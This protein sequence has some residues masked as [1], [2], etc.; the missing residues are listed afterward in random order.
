MRIH[1]LLFRCF[2]PALAAALLFLPRIERAQGAHG[3]LKSDMDP[4]ADACRDFP[5]YADGG[6]L[7]RNPVPAAYSRWGTF[8]ILANHNREI[9]RS[10]LDEAAADRKAA[11]GSERQKLG[12]FY[13]ACMD[14]SKAEADGAKPLEPELER[15]AKVH[16]RGSLDSEIARLQTEGADVLF[17]FGSQQDKKN[18]NEVIAAASQGG[19]GLPDRDYYLKTDEKSKTLRE[20]Y[21]AHVAR[22]LELLGDSPEAARSGAAAVMAIETRLAEA[23]M[24]R[25]ERRDADATYHPMAVAGLETLAP[26]FGWKSF[27]EAVDSPPVKT[28]NI[29]QPKFFEALSHELASVP[30]ADWKTYLRWH[31]V[32][33]A[34]PAL[35]SKFVQ[36]D[37]AFNGEILQGKKEILPRWQRC[38][39][40]TDGSLGFALGRLYVARA[41]PPEAKVRADTMVKNLIA[42][43]REDLATLPWMGEATRKAALEKLNAFTPK[44]GYPDEWRD[45]SAYR[46]ARAS[47]AANLLAGNEF[48]FHRILNKIGQPVD[49]KEWGMTPPTVNAYYNP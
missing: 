30:L 48:E 29:G 46:V 42:A 38:V 1:S 25:V 22:M 12:D 4:T 34:A 41:F 14:E 35:S 9:L 45:Y 13:A 2:S 33:A 40:A 6:W 3:I 37:F 15:I 43:L 10:I 16:D 23:S 32:E 19:L 26:N 47:Y 20:Q 31:L 5:R 8:I 11:S 7:A 17:G 27:L 28:I 44:I 49:R 39:S 21:S 18:S 36:E 24:T